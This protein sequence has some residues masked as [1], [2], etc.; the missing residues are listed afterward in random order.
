MF[1]YLRPLSM[2]PTIIS[3]FPCRIQMWYADRL[4]TR[5]IKLAAREDCLSSALAG[6]D[7]QYEYTEGYRAHLIRLLEESR[8]KRRILKARL[9]EMET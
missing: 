3:L 1:T 8:N 6:L 9:E 4:V 2:I 7:G 5:T